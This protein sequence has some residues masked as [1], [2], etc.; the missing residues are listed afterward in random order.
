M[1]VNVTSNMIAKYNQTR[2][3]VD[4]VNRKISEHK[5]ETAKKVDEVCISER[6]KIALEEKMAEVR[7]EAAPHIKGKLSDIS[8]Q[9]Y[10]DAFGEKLIASEKSKDMDAYFQKMKTICNEMQ[11][12][13]EVKYDNC[14]QEEVYYISQNGEFEM[15]SEDKE[16]ELLDSA[17]ETHKMLIVNSM[18]I[19]ARGLY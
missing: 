4:K 16:L 1:N 9:Y 7:G 10:V 17:Y 6:G 2:I 11:E 15:L 5:A 3:D 18:K 14:M 8:S 19:W 13:I 12:D